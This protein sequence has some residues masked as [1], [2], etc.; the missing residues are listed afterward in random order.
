MDADLS[1]HLLFV[2][3]LLFITWY[4]FLYPCTP[5]YP[6]LPLHISCFNHLSYV[7]HVVINIFCKKGLCLHA[8]AREQPSHLS[9]YRSSCF[10][11]AS[12]FRCFTTLS[13]ISNL[14]HVCLVETSSSIFY[15]VIL[16]KL[17]KDIFNIQNCYL[18]HLPPLPQAV[19]CLCSYYDEVSASSLVT[20]LQNKNHNINKGS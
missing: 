10:L 2:C 3:L 15:L 8:C 14:S 9:L 1:W 7:M 13:H 12:C 17:S 18:H 20:T 4:L 6:L 5:H 11:L 16:R 19:D